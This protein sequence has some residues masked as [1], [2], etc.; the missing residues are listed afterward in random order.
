MNIDQFRTAAR[1]LDQQAQG[2]PVSVRLFLASGVVI[3][4]TYLLHEAEELLQV[5]ELTDCEAL[6]ATDYD[7]FVPLS[8][9]IAVQ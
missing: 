7:M 3:Q 9:I 5:S 2:E 8:A 4:G 1:I 6:V